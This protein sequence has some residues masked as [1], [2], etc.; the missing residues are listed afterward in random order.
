[1]K[2][3]IDINE[4]KEYGQFNNISKH[5]YVA[6]KSCATVWK[7]AEDEFDALVKPYIEE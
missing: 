2:Q 1:M 3:L 6:G 4:N 5:C 7:F